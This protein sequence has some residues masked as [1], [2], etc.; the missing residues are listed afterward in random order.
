MSDGARALWQAAFDALTADAALQGL[1][2]QPPRIF[3]HVPDGTPFPYLVIGDGATLDAGTDTGEGSLHRLLLHAWS[4]ARGRA[5]CRALMDTARAV[6]HEAV[7]PLPGRALTYIRFEGS[8]VLREA[9]GRTWHGLL[10]FI[11][12]SEPDN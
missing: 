8:D 6:L 4:R 2:G 9:D 11:A 12:R 5:E 7:L 10:R 3:D 1:L